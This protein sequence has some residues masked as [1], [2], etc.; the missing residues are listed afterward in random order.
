MSRVEVLGAEE[1][2]PGCGWEGAA[3]P[4]TRGGVARQKGEG[5]V[6]RRGRHNSA[7]STRAKETIGEAG[8]E[9]STCSQRLHREGRAGGRGAARRV[10]RRS[11]NRRRHRCW[12]SWRWARVHGSDVSVPASR[13]RPVRSTPGRADA[14]PPPNRRRRRHAASALQKGCAGQSHPRPSSPR[15]A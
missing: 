5:S 6:S 9:A 14:A 12:P 11:R 15:T 13:L 1:G 8:Y 2:G 7:M 10:R 3:A 4:G